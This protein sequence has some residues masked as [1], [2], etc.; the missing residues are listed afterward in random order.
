SLQ[1]T[2]GRVSYSGDPAGSLRLWE[3]QRDVAARLEAVDP[4]RAAR[5]LHARALARIGVALIE[6]GKTT[7][8]LEAYR[9]ATDA[10]QELADAE[11]ANTD[12]LVELA[13]THTSIA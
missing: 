4:G 12:Y 11:P 5:F 8:S 1:A 7:E 3:E 6:M 13:M 9:E 2:G 10:M